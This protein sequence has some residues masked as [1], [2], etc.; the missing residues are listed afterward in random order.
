MVTG[1][2]SPDRTL[3]ILTT[4]TSTT[5]SVSV[6]ARDEAMN[7]SNCVSKDALVKTI[8][9]IP[10]LTGPIAE[11]QIYDVPSSAINVDV[12]GLLD[13]DKVNI[14]GEAVVQVRRELNKRLQMV[15]RQ[16]FL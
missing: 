1:E 2:T 10:I 5:D 8:S 7:L 11:M 9:L 3:N 12:T 13:G 15:Q 4:I 16:Q 14:F 6:K